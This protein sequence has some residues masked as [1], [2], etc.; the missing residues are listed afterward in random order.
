[1]SEKSTVSISSIEEMNMEAACYSVLLV[2]ICH[3]TRRHTPTDILLS[4]VTISL[5]CRRDFYYID[6]GSISSERRQKP[7]R[8]RGVIT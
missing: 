5:Q 7:S 4:Y 3:I 6:G 2:I 8:L 1:M